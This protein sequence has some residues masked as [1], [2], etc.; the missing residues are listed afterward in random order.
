MKGQ[1]LYT[2]IVLTIIAASLVV[3]VMQNFFQSDSVSAEAKSSD[4]VIDVNIAGVGGYR[5]TGEGI[6]DVNVKNDVDVWVQNIPLYM[7]KE[8][9]ASNI[10]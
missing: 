2:K 1:D 3:L 7:E 5:V 8:G 9:S 6:L 4:E 10:K